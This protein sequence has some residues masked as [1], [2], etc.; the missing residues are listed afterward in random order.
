M[1]SRTYPPFTRGRRSSVLPLS[2]L[3]LATALSA[4]A[5]VT[6]TFDNPGDLTN[7]FTNT[8]STPVAQS[9]TGGLGGSGSIDLTSIAGGDAQYLTFKTPF[10]GNTEGWS[11]SVF[12]YSGTTPAAPVT[13]M[14]ISTA[15]LVNFEGSPSTDGSTIAPFIAFSSGDGDNGSISSMS[16]LGGP[17]LADSHT[18]EMS[19]NLAAGTWYRHDLAVSYLG[20]NEYS[21]TSSIYGVDASGNNPILLATTGPQQYTNAILAADPEV[22][23]FL[24]VYNGGS[25]DD[26]TVNVIPEASSSLAL[27]LGGLALATRRRRAARD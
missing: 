5:A 19:T 1:L 9:S 21:V 12:G 7:Q 18:V 14:G 4:H 15:P 13:Y 26:F 23:F 2:A 3:L 11:V 25:L 27:A 24:G 20:L 8:S 6:V 16:H 10:A 17:G 22:Y